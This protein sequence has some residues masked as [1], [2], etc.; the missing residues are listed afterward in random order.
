MRKTYQL[1]VLALTITLLVLNHTS[2]AC[3]NFLVTKGASTDGST[4]ITYNADS[5]Q[6]FGELYFRPAADYPDGALQK[7]YEW[8]TGKYLGD[9]PQAKHTYSVVGNMNEYQVS[10][11][12]T[13]YGGREE[14]VDTTATV[15]YGSLMYTT[16]QRA[17]TAREAIKVMVELVSQYGYYSEGE[18]FSIADPNEVW[19]LE[20]I[21]KG[22][23][24]KVD[25]KTKKSFNANKGANW[26]AIRIPD[27]Y[28]SAHA[29]HARITTFPLE[30]KKQ[31]NSISS[32]N[33]D[34]V[35]NPE[36]EYIYSYDVID[37]AREKGYFTGKDEEFSFSDIYAPLDFE[38][39]RF[40]EVRVWSFFKDINKSMWDYI[41][42][43]KGKD[44]S[45]RMPLYIKPDRKLTVQDMMGFMGDHLEG[46]ELD[47]TK[48]PGAGPSG[49][50]YRWRPLTWEYQGKT[51]CNERATGTQQTGFTFVAQAR[52]WLPNPIGGIFWFGV[53]DAA[54][55]VFCPMYCGITAVPES[56]AVGN[57]DMLTYSPTCAFW[58]FNKVANFAYLRYDLMSKDIKKLQQE[59]EN[60]FVANSS[61]I[62]TEAKDLYQTDP[63]QA[64]KFITDYSVKAGNDVVAR[65]NK[66]FEYLLVKFMDGNV[67]QE[68]NGQFKW[69]Q[70]RGAPVK[71]LNPEYP[72]WWKKQVIDATGDKLLE[73]S[74]KKE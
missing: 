42:Y 24:I 18:S 25:P 16:L 36:V 52:N 8:D 54:T 60:G 21:G 65:W 71:V 4:F 61:A 62:D 35:F 13:T 44:L 49:L 56:F 12:E 50:P 64:L 20:M 11:G 1:R 7:I 74:T 10:I 3:T 69:N 47:M 9:I 41:E 28:V 51:Y 57:G 17:K 5:H 67:K 2:N 26:V 30:S 70:Y 14:L 37:F 31:K 27:G 66:L 53:D 63:Q 59:L 15:D 29:N 39:A 72:D 6:L 33:L 38:G 46:T 45:K 19:I 40:C 73:P 22:I 32:K 23:D 58:T 55:T 43:A 34:K 48:D 68:E